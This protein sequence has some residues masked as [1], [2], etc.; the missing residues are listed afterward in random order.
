MNMIST[1]AFQT[2][3]DASSKQPTLAKKFAAVW[4]K[5]NAKAARAGGVSLMALSLAACGSD[6]STTTATTDTTTVATPTVPTVVVP[7]IDAVVSAALTKGVDA[8]VG[9]SGNDLF[10]GQAGDTNATIIAGDTV[11][12]GTGTDT[13][14]LATT[15]TAT[16]IAG[17]T[18][19]DVETIRVSDSA[20]TSST[21]NLFGSTGITDLESYASSGA[22]LTFSNVG[23]IADLNLTNT[24]G[25]GTVTLTYTA[26]AVV[27]TADV[28]NVVL[29]GAAA[30]GLVTIAGVETV[31]VV[32]A[33][34]G[35]TLAFLG[36][37]TTK[38]TVDA[39]AKTT[40]DASNAGNTLM[41]AV[42][43][44]A[45]SGAVTLSAPAVTT[46]AVTGGSGAD[47]MTINNISA[48]TTVTGNDGADTV[49]TSQTAL[50]KFEIANLDVET[51]S[52][53]AAPTSL[54]LS[55]NASIKTVDYVAGSGTSTVAGVAEGTS[56]L[57][58]A[59]STSLG[60]TMTD[61][62][63]TADSVNLTVGKAGSTGTLG[64]NAGTLTA[65]GVETINID[66]VGKAIVTG[67]TGVNTLTIAGTSVTTV[68]VDGDRDLTLTQAGSSVKTYDASDS[69][70]TQNTSNIAFAV[71]GA[72]VKGG[73]DK[74]TLTATSAADTIHGNAGND[75]ITGG[76]GNDIIDGGA[77]VD[78]IT[79]GTGADTM[80]GGTGKDVFTIA[81]GDSLSASAMDVIT[82]F[83]SGDDRLALGQTNTKFLGNYTSLE[84]GLAGMTAAN[85]SFFVTG[86]SQL[87][88]VATQGTLQASDD[89]VK[90][91]GVTSVQASDLGTGAL[92]AGAEIELTG[93]SA[94]IN[95]TTKTNSTAK[96]TDLDDT[97]TATQANATTSTIDGALGK[98][99]LKITTGGTTDASNM[100]NIEVLDLTGAVA[101]ATVTNMAASFTEAKLGALGDTVTMAATSGV[102]VTG[103]AL[104]DTINLATNTTGATVN[105]GSGADT[106]QVGAVAASS[107]LVLDGGTGAAFSDSLKIAGAVTANLTGSTL[108]NFEDLTLDIGAA[109]SDVTLTAAQLA[110]FTTITGDDDDDD[111]ITVTTAGTITADADVGD[112]SVVAGSTVIINGGTA[113][114]RDTIITETGTGN[115]TVSYNAAATYTGTHVGLEASDVILVGAGTTDVSGIVGADAA[116]FNLGDAAATIVLDAAQNGANIAGL[117]GTQQVTVDATDTF[118]TILGV[119]TYSTVGGST[120]TVGTGH[121]A[122]DIAGTNAAANTLNI[123]GKT[124]TGTL[125][126]AHTADKIISTTGAD[127]SATGTTAEIN[128]FDGEITMTAAQYQV[129]DA[130]TGGNIDSAGAVATDKVILTTAGGTTAMVLDADIE[131]MQLGNG[132]NTVTVGANDAVITGGTGADT[133]TVTATNSVVVSFDMGSDTTTDRLDINNV[134]E[135]PANTNS[136]A[137]T[138]FNVTHDALTFADGGT[139]ASNAGFQ[140]IVGGSNTNVTAPANGVIELTGTNVADLTGDANGGAVELAMVAAMGNIAN[141]SYTVALYGGTS[142]AGI[143]HV[144]MASTGDAAISTGEIVIELVAILDNVGA[145][146]LSAVNFY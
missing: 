117:T 12:G 85:Q 18:L 138:N 15:G 39:D 108:T 118:T 59:A 96:S 47:T 33:S 144:V 46:L 105:A 129:F 122:V 81:D 111:T 80:T 68:D 34:T 113:A 92:G 119:E 13:F 31:N 44:S 43:M 90:L 135:D 124:L 41:A 7:V 123:G 50:T 65:T 28:Q 126:F 134:T 37:A 84:E 112:Y 133:I 77:G 63:G 32:S 72:T 130:G 36:A 53:S 100:T 35:S 114:L 95:K 128:D 83:T 73:S 141:G 20:T 137:V 98:D 24:G 69:T 104:G 121:E 82:D 79:G 52:F 56:F 26:A 131:A 11:D 4:E 23:S 101:A 93:T 42:D 58:K 88:V 14:T 22:A 97:I 116:T 145:D 54:S 60:V 71:T 2:E 142:D 9:G 25:T 99:T 30:T 143:Y 62:T 21:V 45:S 78:S 120:V 48:K 125:T 74:D 102:S 40:V 109:A 1:G 55:G 17:L 106:V 49:K 86:T 16:T 110:A 115:T 87:Y 140:S 38:M 66:S 8:L 127:I 64:I 51:L 27:G 3:M 19:T 61:A 107:A 146:N 29:S 10:S 139:T 103:G 5:K 89:I 94:T 70:G 75:T 136:V 67:D 91:T 6:D 76:A 57:V 132:T